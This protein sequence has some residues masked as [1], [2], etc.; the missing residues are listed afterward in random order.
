MIENIEDSQLLYAMLIVLIEDLG[1]VVQIQY[2]KVKEIAEKQHLE[3]SAYMDA[4]TNSI[5]LELEEV[6][7][8]SHSDQAAE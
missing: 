3:M 7:N 5:F 1:G 8:D 4:E 2:S 6:K